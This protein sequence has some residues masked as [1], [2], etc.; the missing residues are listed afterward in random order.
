MFTKIGPVNAALTR[1]Y[2]RSQ[3]QF[4]ARFSL[5]V[6]AMFIKNSVFKRLN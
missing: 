1:P 6:I 4:C 5:A 3:I 2:G